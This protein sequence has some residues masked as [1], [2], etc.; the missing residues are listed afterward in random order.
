[1][2]RLICI[3]HKADR[4]VENKMFTDNIPGRIKK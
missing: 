1:M 3:Y 4:E 2:F